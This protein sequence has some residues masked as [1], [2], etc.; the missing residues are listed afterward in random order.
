MARRFTFLYCM[1][2]LL[3]SFHFR[4][5]TGTVSIWFRVSFDTQYVSFWVSTIAEY[6]VYLMFGFEYRLIVSMFM[7]GFEYSLTLSMFYVSF[8]VSCDTQYM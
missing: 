6:S 3:S 7:F 5:V 4:G 2:E 1:F 8:R